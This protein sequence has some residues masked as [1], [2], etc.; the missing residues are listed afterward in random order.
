M[1]FIEF[2]PKWSRLARLS[3]ALATLAGPVCAMAQST[4]SARNP[5]YTIVDLGPVGPAS[6]QGQ[7]LTIS[8]NGL[9]SGETVLANP[10]NSGEWVSHAVLWEGTHTRRSLATP[11][12]GGPNS[13]AYG[14]N[15][16]GHA[17]G[18]ADTETPDPNVED[19]CGSKALGLTHSGNTC[20]PFFWQHGTMIALPRLQIG[21][22][23]V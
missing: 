11:G 10:K 17:V 18:Q 5:R 15:N 14:V 7:P 23:H 1:N 21:R 2:A 4:D 8:G 19:F 20:V 16:W 12:L 3:L 22:A 6:S 13:V 9:V